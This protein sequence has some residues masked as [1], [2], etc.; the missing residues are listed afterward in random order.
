MYKTTI[1]GD[2]LY[3]T[4]SDG[5]GEAVELFGA[6]E[7]GETP[8]SLVN[9]A[10]ASCVTMCVQSYLAKKEGLEEVSVTVKG[11]YEADAFSLLIDLP[12]T[13]SEQKEADL[14]AYVDQFCRVK[15]LLREDLQVTVALA[16]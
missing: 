10:L 16:K 12:L 6:T 15:K 2:R 1:K 11:S 7:E 4:V 3:H 8:M 14:L 9:L 5:Y 13:L